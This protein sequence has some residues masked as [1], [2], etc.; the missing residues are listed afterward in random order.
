MCIHSLLHPFS[1]DDGFAT[2]ELAHPTIHPAPAFVLRQ[3]VYQAGR[4][5]GVLPLDV[6]VVNLGYDQIHAGGAGIDPGDVASI[7][8]GRSGEVGFTPLLGSG[9]CYRRRRPCQYQRTPRRGL[10]LFMA[11]P[12]STS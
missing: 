11:R 1:N 8:Q 4:V 5:E 9:N 3:T 6:P 7:A 12:R 10:T 2:P